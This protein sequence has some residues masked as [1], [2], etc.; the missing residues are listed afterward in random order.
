MPI[1]RND[2]RSILLASLCGDL[3][4]IKSLYEENPDIINARGQLKHSKY[5]LT[6]VVYAAS[7]FNKKAFIDDR[8]KICLRFLVEH[9]ADLDAEIIGNVN[10]VCE[11]L[12]VRKLIK[13]YYPLAT[14]F[15]EEIEREMIFTKWNRIP[16][17][18]FYMK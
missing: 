15:I 11:T 7:Q 17:R 9:G 13:M 6:P 2:I 10:G 3:S 4:I 18:L 1:S 12:T 14:K 16:F 5:L 8:Y